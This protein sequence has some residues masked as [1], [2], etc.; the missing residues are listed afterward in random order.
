[1]TLTTLSDRWLVSHEPGHRN[2]IKVG[3]LI[4]TRQQVYCVMSKMAVLHILTFTFLTI[5]LLGGGFG[6]SDEEFQVGFI[7]NYIFIHNKKRRFT[8]PY[9][10]L[11]QKIRPIVAEVIEEL[12]QEIAKE[13]RQE[14]I[15]GL[16]EEITKEI[17][18]EVQVIII[19]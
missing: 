19:Y 7:K 11:C 4:L 9:L 12:K 2:K 14:V 3:S 13:I 1:M 5:T 16:R 8:Q 6:F 15:Q 10:V 17:K 18:D